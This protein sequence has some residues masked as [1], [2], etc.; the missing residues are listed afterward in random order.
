MF[1]QGFS[2]VK[3]IIEPELAGFST[4]CARGLSVHQGAHR[5][6]ASV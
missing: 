1:L 3:E 5:G 4:S 2:G 6:A